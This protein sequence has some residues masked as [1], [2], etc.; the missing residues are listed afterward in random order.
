PVVHTSLPPLTT[1]YVYS[2]PEFDDGYVYAFII[3]AV[4][5]D[6]TAI[7]LSNSRGYIIENFQPIAYHYIR[8]A[9]VDSNNDIFM[10]FYPDVDASTE[11][12]TIQRSTDNS[13]YLT[14]NVQSFPGGVPPT[15]NYTDFSPDPATNSYY[16]RSFANDACA[17]SVNSGYARTVLLNGN[18]QPDF[19]NDISWNAFE[20]EN[21]TVL[22]YNLYRTESASPVLIATLTPDVTSYTDDVV[23]FLNEV[24][25]ICYQIEAVFTL[26][27]PAIGISEQLSSFS[28]TICLELSPRIYVPNAIAPD[29]INNFF[30][31]VI[32]NGRE[33]SYTMQI[34]DRYGKLL[35]ETTQVDEPWYGTYQ[36]KTVPTGTY[37]Y[38]ITFTATN[39]QIVTKRG[40]V[41]V[42]K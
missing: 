41:T 11:N 12:I 35:F 9:T 17:N 4:R 39:G 10:Q 25:Q 32:L 28:N 15:L 16:Y 31:P 3:R 36:G 29:G 30:K 26:N 40:N 5:A 13:S 7:S 38:V 6:G 42:V 23:N 14:I 21:G 33:D 1:S 8:N 2:G 20:I 37:G 34:F 27:I 18:N 22:Y 24:E 19:T